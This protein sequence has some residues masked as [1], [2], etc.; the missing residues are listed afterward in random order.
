MKLKLLV[1]KL[2]LT[3]PQFYKNTYKQT[4]KKNRPSPRGDPIRGRPPK[5]KYWNQT[6]TKIRNQ[7]KSRPISTNLSFFELFLR[8]AEL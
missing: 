2:L 7:K 3:S 4:D 8:Q 5:Q 1:A 6:K